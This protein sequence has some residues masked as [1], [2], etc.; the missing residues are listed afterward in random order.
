MAFMWAVE[1]ID[2]HRVYAE[3]RRVQPFDGHVRGGIAERSAALFAAHHRPLDAVPMAQ[4]GGSGARVTVRERAADGGGR[5]LT[6]VA[7]EQLRDGHAKA[8][9]RAERLQIGGIARAPLAKAEIRADN[10][11]RKP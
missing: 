9:L 10:H 2:K 11:M 4:H 6:G 1:Y 5:D 3:F 7:F 8:H